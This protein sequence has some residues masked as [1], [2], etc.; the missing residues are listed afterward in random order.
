MILTGVVVYLY[1]TIQKGNRDKLKLE[2]KVRYEQQKQLD[3][4]KNSNSSQDD[5]I[6]ELEKKL[7]SK[8]DEKARLAAIE[9]SKKN[10]SQQVVSKVVPTAEAATGAATG[11]EY[12]AK[13]FIYMKESGNNPNAV[14]KSSGA[15]G[16]GQALPCAKMG[17]AL[18]DYAC[19]DNWATNYMKSRYGTWL[20][21][22]AFWLSHR[23]W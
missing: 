8:L 14:N 15:C 16:L 23:W 2:Q 13:M 1:S 17:C 11:D 19:Q 20:N 5:K 21:A 22:K 9:A 6:K 3:E 10:V 7:Q 12:E 4:L 18:G